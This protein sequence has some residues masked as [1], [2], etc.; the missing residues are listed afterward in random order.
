MPAHI[1]NAVLGVINVGKLLFESTVR[2][3]LA[4][5]QAGSRSARAVKTKRFNGRLFERRMSVEIEI[6]VGGEVEVLHAADRRFRLC[7]AVVTKEE[8][9]ENAGTLCNL[10]LHA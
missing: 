3:S 5:D 6:V 7:N 2:R 8:R 9:I 4:R 10:L 1:D